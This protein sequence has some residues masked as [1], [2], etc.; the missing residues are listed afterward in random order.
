MRT[1]GIDF[2]ERRI[3]IAISDPEGRFAM[4]FE[5]LERTDDRRALRTLLAIIRR[6]GS[7]ASWSAIR[8]DS[9]APPGRQA[10]A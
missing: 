2:G 10:S 3:G 8:V 7:S 6:E 9:T 5:T 4:P 1:L